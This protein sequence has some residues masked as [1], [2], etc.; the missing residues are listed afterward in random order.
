MTPPRTN[1]EY[2]ERVGL[3]LLILMVILV[4]LFVVV[5]GG[6]ALGDVLGLLQ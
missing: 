4:G 1:R 6:L 5:I 3:I 2:A